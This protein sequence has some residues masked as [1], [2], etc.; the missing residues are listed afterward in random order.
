MIPIVKVAT[1][2]GLSLGVWAVVAAESP[3]LDRWNE[4][5]GVSSGSALVLVL[6]PE[7]AAS[8]NAF[9]DDFRRHLVGRG[10]DELPG[11]L[12]FHVVA[13]VADGEELPD[14]VSDY[15][16]RMR[17]PATVAAVQRSEV[18]TSVPSV[19]LPSVFAIHEGKVL[20]HEE[21][22]NATSLSVLPSLWGSV[23]AG[24]PGR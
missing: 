14:F 19:P 2:I 13:V 17:L 1:S 5:L 24:P 16:L 22:T 9:L 3:E 6:E 4:Q 23:R 12:R 8:C 20:W 21:V 18:G 15:F 11:D 7:Q 10:R